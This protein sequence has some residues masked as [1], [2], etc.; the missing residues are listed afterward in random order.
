MGDF[1]QRGAAGGGVA[2]GF[3][4]ATTFQ[5]Q[6]GPAIAFG[7]LLGKTFF[8]SGKADR[9][10]NPGGGQGGIVKSLFRLHRSGGGFEGGFIGGGRFKSLSFL[11]EKI[12]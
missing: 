4:H 2:L 1:F 9:I 7:K 11:E 5:C 10:R 6:G 12:A 3:E 8:Q